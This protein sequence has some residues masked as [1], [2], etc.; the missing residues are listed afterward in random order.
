MITNIEV[1]SAA[2]IAEMDG[3]GGLEGWRWIFILEGLVT[4]LIGISCAFLLI[5]SPALSTRWLDPEE[6]RYLELSMFIKQG[7][8]FHS[9]TGFR[10]KDLKMAMKN[11][12][13]YC[14]AYFLF[15][16]SAL[17]YGELLHEATLTM[18]TYSDHM[19]NL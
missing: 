16:Q 8:K 9:E 4:V 7:G 18:Q 19:D 11:W 1:F 15:V 10:F 2:A 5:D 13:I 17:S 6:I 14:Q 12:R 3:V